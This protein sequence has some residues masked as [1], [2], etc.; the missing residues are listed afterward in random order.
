LTVP[1]GTLDGE[2][3]GE[4]DV[5]G[6]LDELLL[7]LLPHPAA[8]AVQVMASRARRGALF[9]AMRGIISR[10]LPSLVARRK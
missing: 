10:T 9:L 6:V 8:S 1:V 2:L 4:L 3:A 5:V 7:A